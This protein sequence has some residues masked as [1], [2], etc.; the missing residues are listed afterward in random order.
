M[1]SFVLLN[2]N[3]TLIQPD[4]FGEEDYLSILVKSHLISFGG[5]AHRTA[6]ISNLDPSGIRGGGGHRQIGKNVRFM[7]SCKYTARQLC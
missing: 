2:Q 4:F 6:M 1:P 5:G 7:E 3:T